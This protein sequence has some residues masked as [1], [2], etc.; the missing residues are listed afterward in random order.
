MSRPA[1]VHPHLPRFAQAVTGVICLEALVFQDPW[2][3]AVA[4]GLIAISLTAP[5]LSPVHFLFRL[6]ARPATDLEPVAPVR[7]AQGMAAVILAL[8]LGLFAAGLD[9]AAWVVVGLIAVVALFSAIS[10]FCVGCEIYRVLLTRGGGDGDVR[11]GLG[12]TGAG[13]WLV[14]L[15]APGC[16]RCEPV[17]R[18]LEE[19]ASPRGIVRVDLTRTPAGARLPV[20][21]VPA[22]IAIGGDGRVRRALTGRLD[23]PILEEAAAAV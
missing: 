5:R 12:L 11:E 18:Q 16:A 8:A 7:F 14:V 13:P 9:T 3:V 20:R 23:R 1:A 4:L 15:T 19:V 22:V 17:A 10:G 2:S 6:V 21:S